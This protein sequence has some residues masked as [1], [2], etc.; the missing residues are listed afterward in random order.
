MTVLAQTWNF[1]GRN[2]NTCQVVPFI[3]AAAGTQTTLQHF[4]PGFGLAGTIDVGFILCAILGAIP[5][6]L[7]ADSRAGDAQGR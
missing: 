6:V 4:S 3:P 7:G 1:F 5:V 2:P